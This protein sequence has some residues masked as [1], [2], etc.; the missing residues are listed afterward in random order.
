M[1][2]SITSEE[3]FED[4]NK[5]AIFY[6]NSNGGVTLSGGDPL[7]QPDFSAA[8]LRRCHASGL[9]TAIETSGFGRW[10]LLKNLLA[11]TDL[12]L[13]DLKHM[14]T[15]AHKACT[16]VPNGLILDNARRICHEL[17]LPMIIRVPVVPGYNDSTENIQQLGAFVASEL[18]RNVSVHLLPYHRLGIGKNEQL[19]QEQ[20]LAD[21]VPP[22]EIH[23]ENLRN[24]L[25][26]LNLKIDM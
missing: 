6:A 19:E 18:G 23:M 26:R 25:L 4:V 7:F 22:D 9:H 3:V 10:E 20:P 16:G 12:V 5:D 11:H 15:E 14:E 2:Y 1:G 8:V 13:Y 17:K 24:I 21:V